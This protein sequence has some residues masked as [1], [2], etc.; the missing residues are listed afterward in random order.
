MK[1][2][3]LIAGLV[4]ALIVGADL[5]YLIAPPKNQHNNHHDPDHSYSTNHPDG[6]SHPDTD[7]H[8]N[9]HT[10]R[11]PDS[12]GNPTERATDEA[13]TRICLIHDS[14]KRHL[15]RSRGGTAST[16]RD[17]PGTYVKIGDKTLSVY[18]FTVVL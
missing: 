11:D 7:S 12:D 9:R 16:R 15:G 3:Q 8:T 10:N 2:G 18:N 17:T 4:A 13:R 5:G 14:D 6:D 1:T